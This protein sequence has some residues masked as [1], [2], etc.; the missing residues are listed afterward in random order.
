[1]IKEEK[2]SN[3]AKRIRTANKLIQKAKL[4][5]QYKESHEVVGTI[6]TACAH[7][8]GFVW[9]YMHCLFPSKFNIEIWKDIDSMINSLK[10]LKSVQSVYNYLTTKY[11]SYIKLELVKKCMPMYVNDI[12]MSDRELKELEDKEI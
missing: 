2:N 12:E 8:I 11:D 6:F 1:M 10:E 4:S 9:L 3:D 5:K 7:N